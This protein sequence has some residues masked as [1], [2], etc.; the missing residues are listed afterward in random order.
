MDNMKTTTLLLFAI[1]I[2]AQA[3]PQ[4]REHN[5]N[6]IIERQQAHQVQGPPT[7]RLIIGRRQ[8]DVYKNG[9]MFEKNNVVGV[10]GGH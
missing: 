7:S 1:A 10:K 5:R 4:R 8:I 9:V 6:Y 2:T 3:E